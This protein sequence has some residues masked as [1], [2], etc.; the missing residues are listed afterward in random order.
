MG[1][2]FLLDHPYEIFLKGFISYDISK[3]HPTSSIGLNYKFTIISQFLQS[4][5]NLNL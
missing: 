4:N 2:P 3:S 1:E 5:S